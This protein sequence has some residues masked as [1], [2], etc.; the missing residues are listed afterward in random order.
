MRKQQH[1]DIQLLNPHASFSHN[2]LADIYVNYLVSK[3]F[4]FVNPFIL[5]YG[6]EKISGCYLVYFIPLPQRGQWSLHF[7]STV[8]LIVG[9]I[10][11]TAP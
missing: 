6:L 11:T 10:T 1:N 4:L 2:T 5:K 3:L 7:N 9:I 8:K